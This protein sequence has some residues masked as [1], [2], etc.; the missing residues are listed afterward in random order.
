MQ[1]TLLSPAEVVAGYRAAAQ[2]YPAVPPMIIWR[3]WEYAAYRRC[4]LPEPALDLGCGDGRFFRLVWPR[5][6]QV[7]GVD[8]DPS[9]VDAARHLGVYREVHV[10]AAHALPFA[11]GQFASAL[12]NCSL[13]H[14]DHLPQVL[15]N[16][17]RCLRPGG[18][19]LLSVVTDRFLAWAP[20]PPLLRAAGAPERAEALL[21]AYARYH[22]LV[23]VF[24][25]EG[26]IAALER[27]GFRVEEH[28]PLVPEL[29]GRLFLFLDQLWHLPAA[30]GEA[31]DVLA[32]AL[33]GRPGLVEALS[34]WLAMENDWQQC[35]GAVLRAQ[36]R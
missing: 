32:A 13:E 12:A 21:A 14:M 10:A 26:W 19:F 27:A 25:P 16:V 9:A 35:C 29:T 15:E 24:T 30:P 34:G 1:L 17:A 8:I 4:T 11:E 20:L 33:M 3:G 36:S 7:V 31:G 6:R 5:V 22:H 28:I 2:L 23:N 18:E